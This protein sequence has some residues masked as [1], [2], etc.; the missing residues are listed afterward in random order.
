MVKSAL[1]NSLLDDFHS[2][3]CFQA[4]NFFGCNKADDGSFVFRVWA[5]HAKSV[6]LCKEDLKLEMNLLS[7]SESYE[8][9]CKAQVGERYNFLIETHDGRALIK[10]D[11]YAFKSDYPNSFASIVCDLE[12]SADY[13]PIFQKQS[14]AQP[15][16]IYEVNLLS[17]KRHSDNSYYTY[18]ELERELVPYV[19]DMG[20]THVEFMPVTEFP[21]DG[22]WGYQ[23]TG[24]FSVTSRLGSP[25]DFKR[26]IDA[27]H[28]NSIK[29]ILDWVPAHFPKDDWGLYEFD[30][31]P[32][33]ES[34]LWDR[35]EHRNW[36]T[37]KFDFGRGE[38]DSFLLS[39]AYFFFDKYRIDG[40]RVDA[41]AAMLYLDY[42]R[43]AG[44]YTPNI[45]GDNRNLEA[46]EFLKKF[47]LLIKNKFQGA[48][49]IAEESTVYDGVTRA[50]ENGGLGFDY[51]WN[52]GWMNDT[53]FYCRQDPYFRS[54]HHNKITFSLVYAFSE[55][56]ILPLSH[57]EVV[58]VKGSIVNKMP[59]EYENK[60]A[61][62][63]SLLAYMYAHPGKKLNFMGYEIAQFKEWDYR[64]QIE[65]FLTEY[66]L[67]AKMQTFVKE[68]NFFYKNCNPLFEIDDGWDGYEWLVVDDK[69]NNVIAF[70]RYGE[71]GDSIVAIVNFSGI[72]LYGYRIGIERGKYRVVFNTDEKRFGG[73]GKLR[74]KVFNSVK[75]SSHGKENSIVVDI[76]KLT[77]IYLKKINN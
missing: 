6:Y 71:N 5:P 7:D 44:D 17:W 15:V 67:H 28:A 60:F 22:S 58:H 29:V 27:F 52:M 2:G 63:R 36:G 41:V 46:I 76:P 49:T 39:S 18:A 48:I 26:L 21:Y 13:L 10:A 31:Q 72:P 32:L 70:S 37:R 30:G 66:E 55:R 40:L 19:K 33:Y 38:V 24:Y 47:N 23:V 75:Q 34:S 11:P 4:Y 1:G 68:L 64:S 16:N 42:D 8:I 61:G 57:D 77:C 74:K 56:F 73:E 45:Y 25:A 3:K 65:Y 20:Y 54:Y 35:M 62:E 59:G 69:F 43:P 51:K 14:K 50:V 12:K 9:Y 53:L